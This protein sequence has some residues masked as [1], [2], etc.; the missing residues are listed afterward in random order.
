MDPNV[1]N[2]LPINGCVSIDRGLEGFGSKNHS[3]HKGLFAFRR[4]TGK[5]QDNKRDLKKRKP[6]FHGDTAI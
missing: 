6:G 4:T 5:H 2:V 3:F 1:N